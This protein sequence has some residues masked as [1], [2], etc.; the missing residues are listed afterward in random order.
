[1]EHQIGLHLIAK[2]DH[3]T[4]QVIS[5]PWRDRYLIENL[6]LHLIAQLM[7]TAHHPNI[8]II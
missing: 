2:K 7:R 4:Y 8:T 5:L 3:Q 1:M 6:A